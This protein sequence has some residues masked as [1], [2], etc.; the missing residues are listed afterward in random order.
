MVRITL[1]TGGAAALAVTAC[2]GTPDRS[3]QEG[4]KL[5]PGG[6]E[7]VMGTTR[8]DIPGLGADELELA[9]LEANIGYPHVDDLCLEASDLKG[10][11]RSFIEETV[12]ADQDCVDELTIADGKV[13]GTI[14][15]APFDGAGDPVIITMDGTYGTGGFTTT[16]SSRLT[17]AQYPEGYADTEFE[18]RGKRIEDCD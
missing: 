8:L 17:S 5:R 11:V 12:I 16:G 1:C 2:S 14:T 10:G 15:C 3:A 9:R 18:F 6:W 13:S 7:I 4:V